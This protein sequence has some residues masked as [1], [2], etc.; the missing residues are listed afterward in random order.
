MFSFL[1]LATRLL[2]V[3]LLSQGLFACEDTT[4]E[5][6]QN[7]TLEGVVLDGVN[8]QPVAN[9]AIT[10]NPATSS[11]TTD[12]QGRFSIASVPL[13]K[14]AL[15]IRKTDY[16]Q[17]TVNV[18]VNQ[19]TP[20]EVKIILERS[21]GSNK[22]PNVPA[23]PTPADRATNQPTSV[24]LRWRSTDPDG[25]S[26]T[27][28]NDVILYE[29]GS[30]DRRQLLSN[31]RDTTVVANNLKYN[32][33]YFWQVT[34]RDKAG[35]TVKGD[36]WSF[37]TRAQPDN[38]FLFAREENGNT[39]VYSSDETGANLLRLTSSA[40]VETAPQLSPNR[41]RV[42]YTSNATGQ[43]Q[44]YTMNRDGSDAR[45]VTLIPVDGYF[46]QGIGYRWSPDGAQL[47]YSSYNKLYRINRDGTGLTLLATAPQDRHF[48]ECDWTAQGNRIIVQTVGVSVYDSEL[49][50]LNAD[51]SNR[52]LLVSNL[53]G[54]LDSPSFSIDG[55]RVLYTRDLDGYED[56]TGRQL[57]AHIFTQNLD[58]SG[59]VDVSAG[60]GGTTTTSKANGF[61]DVVPRYAPDGSKIIFAQVNNVNRSIPD[62]YTVDLDGRNRTRLFQNATLSDWK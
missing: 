48:R 12:A 13:G 46:N 60:P 50:L 31:S 51:G 55:R 58:G 27:L 36:I 32:T 3:L 2:L 56:A 38:R 15:S 7:G 30:T 21:T 23:S 18:Q 11:Y 57:N 43:F 54:R 52:T 53:P 24:T 6:G 25:K 41:D 59:L 37:Q 40:F 34:V 39:D 17:E 47:L 14:Y 44:I 8:N 28:R 4:V 22:R 33:T 5:P 20:T 16:K 35:E 26:D 61:N 42:A 19:N 29:S 45:Q 62:I 49:Y 9:A 1:R 10:T